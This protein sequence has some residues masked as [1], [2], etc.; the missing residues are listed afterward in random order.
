VFNQFIAY[1]DKKVVSVFITVFVRQSG[2]VVPLASQVRTGKGETRS[3]DPI[4]AGYRR[5]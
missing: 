5:R 3:A 1:R 4:R 2:A